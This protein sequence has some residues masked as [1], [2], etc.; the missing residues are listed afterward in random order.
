MTTISKENEKGAI[1]KKEE[2][3]EKEVLDEDEG[4]N[5]TAKEASSP[6]IVKHRHLRL[7][8]FMKPSLSLTSL[9]P[10][11]PGERSHETSS[12]IERPYN[13]LKVS[14]ALCHPRTVLIKILNSIFRKSETLSRKNYGE[15]LGSHKTL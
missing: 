12:A 15:D 8:N 13:S 3:D 14:V 5:V 1:T 2:E 7:L 10:Q 11:S 4:N 6:A 9:P